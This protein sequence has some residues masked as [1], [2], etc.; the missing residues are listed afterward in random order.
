MGQCNMIEYVKLVSNVQLLF[1][2]RYKKMSLKF[3]CIVLMRAQTSDM[4][5][6]TACEM[7]Y[8]I[9]VDYGF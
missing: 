9:F 8:I 4:C 6:S 5:H 3:L 7:E 2:L 1:R